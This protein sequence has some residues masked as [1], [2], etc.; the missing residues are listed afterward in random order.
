MD[1]KSEHSDTSRRRICTHMI[2][3]PTCTCTCMYIIHWVSREPNLHQIGTSDI[4]SNGWWYSSTQCMIYLSC[5]CTLWM[6][7]Q[8]TL[9]TCRRGIWYKTRDSN[10]TGSS[11]L[12]HYSAFNVNCLCLLSGVGSKGAPGAGGPPFCV[13][14]HGT[15]RSTGVQGL[16]AHFLALR[17][18]LQDPEAES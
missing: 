6:S 5:T 13:W 7:Y 18:C 15:I 2:H 9:A 1:R 17:M 8:C 16:G 14:P 11:I 10:P 12:F 4:T 3:T